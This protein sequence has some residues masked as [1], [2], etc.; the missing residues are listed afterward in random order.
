MSPHLLVVGLGTVALATVTLATVTLA[1]LCAGPATDRSR[2][3][4]LARRLRHVTAHP[5]RLNRGDV[6]TL[7][8]LHDLPEDEVRL[9]VDRSM[10]L[11]IAPLTLWLWIQQYDVHSLVLTVAADVAH[12]D[13]LRHLAERTVPDLAELE[14]FAALN[15][16][17]TGS[18]TPA[19]AA[20]A[21]GRR[22]R[23]PG[24]LAA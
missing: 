1:A 8:R 15:G 21:A 19:R 22:A 17:Q 6:A 3:R 5:D 13:L 10:R 16:L 4:D 20:A 23:F 11:G 7:M 24:R 14:V 12:T 18:P 9:V 2:R